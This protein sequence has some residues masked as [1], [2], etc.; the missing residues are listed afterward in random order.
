MKRQTT[1]VAF[2]LDQSG[3]MSVTK[4]DAVIGYNELIQQAKLNCKEQN[5]F[6][7]LVT[8]NGDVFEHIWCQ[9]ASELST[10]SEEDYLTD[11]STALKDAIGYTISKLLKTTDHNDEDT[12]Y[13]INVISDG[14]ENASRHFKDCPACSHKANNEDCEECKGTRNKLKVL[15][16][17]VQSTKRWTITYMG[18]DEKYLKQ[19]A[20]ETSIPISNMA[21]WD[22]RP[23][24]A[25]GAMF[26]QKAAL[27]KYYSARSA[28]VSPQN[29]IYSTDSKYSADFTNVTQN[30]EQNIKVVKSS[31]P[32]PFCNY[33]PVNWTI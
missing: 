22:A 2:I 32:T 6:C 9:P 33:K 25:N 30:V 12:S 31:G 18:C 17:S 3:S 19:V 20:R 29:C 21:K 10:A 4:K 8:F 15:L 27:G 13:L 14:A 5:I 24:L 11:G 7:S 23:G 16:E 1:H 28:G 26:R